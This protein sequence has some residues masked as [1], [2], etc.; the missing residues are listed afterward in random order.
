MGG[1]GRLYG[2]R[3][4]INIHELSKAI[5]R[6]LAL[7]NISQKTAARQAG[8]SDST[9]SRTALGKSRPDFDIFIRL[10]RWLD[11]P[12]ENFI[13]SDSDKIVIYPHQDPASV[14]AEL[15]RRDPKMKEEYKEALIAIFTTAYR[16]LKNPEAEK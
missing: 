2:V 15:I 10:C 4:L 9:L 7:D 13:N 14:A 6:K 1:V 5:R 16:E 11:Q 8:V 12:A 3:M